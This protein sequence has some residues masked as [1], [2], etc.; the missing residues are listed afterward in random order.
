M[1]SR[2]NGILVKIGLTYLAV[3][4]AILVRTK[5]LQLQFIVVHMQ[6]MHNIGIMGDVA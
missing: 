3:D 2:L 1:A 4:L 6:N 5:K